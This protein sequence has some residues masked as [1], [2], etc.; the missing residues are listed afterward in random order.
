MNRSVRLSSVLVLAGT[1]LLSPAAFAQTKA[2]DDAAAT[3]L[4][5]QGNAEMDALHYDKALEKFEQALTRAKDPT[6]RASLTYNK[7]RTLQ[8]MGNY[9]LALEQF[10]AF[11]KDAPADLKAKVVGFGPLLDDVRNRVAQLSVRCSVAGAEIRVGERVVGTCSEG[12]TLVR[13]N[14]GKVHLEVRKDGY[15]PFA[16]D[17]ELR[18]REAVVVPAMLLSTN[19]MGSLHIESVSGAIARVDGKDLGVVPVDTAVEPGNHVVELSKSGFETTKKSVLI[20]IGERKVLK[21]DELATP[22]VTSKAWFWVTVG[23]AVAV[24]GAT[25]FTVIYA[26]NKEQPPDK[27]TIAPGNV[28]TGVFRF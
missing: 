1:V 23:T 2:D 15:F 28:S 11:D 16:K 26:T 13:V 22:P 21:V 19:T 25:V 3:Q 17:L 18:G 14:A 6:L 24:I 5:E 20:A 9:P 10:E 4:K 8:A 7:G 27:G 12:T